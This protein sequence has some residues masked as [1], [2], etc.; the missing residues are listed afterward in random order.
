MKAVSAV[1]HKG[2]PPH[3]IEELYQTLLQT[4]IPII[5]TGIY[6]Y[7]PMFDDLA[8]SGGRILT[9]FLYENMLTKYK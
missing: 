4:K 3:A 5:A 1:N 6:E 9:S 7:N 2:F 8:N